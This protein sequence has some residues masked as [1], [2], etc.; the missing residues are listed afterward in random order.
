[1][2]FEVR[3][4]MH[5]EWNFFPPFTIIFSRHSLARVACPPAYRFE[6]ICLIF[7]FLFFVK[8]TLTNPTHD[9]TQTAFAEFRK[10]FK[11][12][13]VG[14]TVPKTAVSEAWRNLSDDERKKYFDAVES[15]KK[16][17]AKKA[18]KGVE[19][20]TGVLEAGA[21][22]GAKKKQKNLGGEGNNATPVLRE[23]RKFEDLNELLHIFGPASMVR[24]VGSMLTPSGRVKVQHFVRDPVLVKYDGGANELSIGF[25]VSAKFMP[26]ERKSAVSR[27]Y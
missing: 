14:E 21:A 16:A 19:S 13:H 22:A 18:R 8:I 10:V 23:V 11:K 5:A 4:L 6:Y 20:A 24:V 15:A 25:G 27:G 1:M 9:I 2:G 12:T 17:S 7:R 3:F 26:M